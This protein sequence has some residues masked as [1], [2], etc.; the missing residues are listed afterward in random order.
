MIY[1]I[2][3][4]SVF[5]KIFANIRSTNSC[6]IIGNAVCEYTCVRITLTIMHN[7]Y[8][9]RVMFLRLNS[10]IWLLV[11]FLEIKNVTCYNQM[12]VPIVDV[13]TVIIRKYKTASQ[14]TTI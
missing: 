11:I 7:A 5:Y 1:H 12:I 6:I 10:V 8:Q 9:I 13:L 14:L 2:F 3:S 4:N